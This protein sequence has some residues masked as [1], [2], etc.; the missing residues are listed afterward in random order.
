[1]AKISLDI[2]ADAKLAAKTMGSLEASYLVGMYQYFLNQRI[3][4][5]N[6]LRSLPDEPSNALM[7]MKQ[8]MEEGEKDCRVLLECYTDNHPIASVIKQIK[9][10]GS[11]ISAGYVAHVDMDKA[12]HFPQVLAYGGYSPTAVWRKGERR[13]YNMDFRK[14]L[15]LAGRSFVFSSGSP[16]SYFGKRYKL[17]KTRIEWHNEQGH[18]ADVAAKKLSMFKFDEA[19][20]TYKA[21]IKGILPPAHIIR[22]A[23]FKTVALFVGVVHDYWSNQLGRHIE[24]YPFAILGHDK[25][26]MV[27]MDEVLTYEKEKNALAKVNGKKKEGAPSY[28]EYLAW[29]ETNFEDGEK[30]EDTGYEHEFMKNMMGLE[31]RE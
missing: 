14:I 4:V 25:L 8:Q 10:I 27:T 5:Q 11:I 2:M 20:S 19:S 21:Y 3:A 13:S 1:M 23:A 12:K 24:P 30:Q 22:L 29:V 28:D 6:R 31:R 26:S 9:G 18:Y 17:F 16:I 15:I 7:Y